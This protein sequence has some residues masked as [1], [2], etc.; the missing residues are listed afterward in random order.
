MILPCGLS[1]PLCSS[2]QPSSPLC[3]TGRGGWGG[4]GPGAR[5]PAHGRALLPRA[6]L[7]L[8]EDELKR[9]HEFEEQCVQEHFQEKEDEQQSSSDERIRV[10]AE[11]CARPG[12]RVAPGAPRTRSPRPRVFRRRGVA[13]STLAPWKGPEVTAV[14]LC[15]K[16]DDESHQIKKSGPFLPSPKEGASATMP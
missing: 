13:C 11:R 14:I 10:T 8:G 12:G 6:E 2:G 1:E 3:V 7:F 9:L 15:V 16:G 4:R 5:A